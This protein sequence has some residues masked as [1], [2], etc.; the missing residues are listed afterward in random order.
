VTYLLATP[1]GWS[2]PPA[3]EAVVHDYIARYVDRFSP[4]VLR[5]VKSPLYGG[6]A[7]PERIATP[8]RGG[9][10]EGRPPR[11]PSVMTG[12]TACWSAGSRCS[13]W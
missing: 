9:S 3:Y 6:A 1:S 5:K 12:A 10:G 2:G 13:R 11:R 8:W 4:G 7:V